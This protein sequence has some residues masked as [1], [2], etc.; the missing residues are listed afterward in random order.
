[1]VLDYFTRY[2]REYS[3]I[4]SAVIQAEIFESLTT[5]VFI[6]WYSGRYPVDQ[7]LYCED[8]FLPWGVVYRPSRR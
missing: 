4:F 2:I 1:M 6:G 8:D 3:N 5:N 7:K